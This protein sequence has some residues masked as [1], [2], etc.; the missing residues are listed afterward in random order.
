MLPRGPLAK[1]PS[2]PFFALY[3]FREKAASPR[4]KGRERE[5]LSIL[6]SL[7]P[8]PEGE[9]DFGKK[10][11]SELPERLSMIEWESNL[12]GLCR[13]RGRG[14]PFFDAGEE[15]EAKEG[16]DPELQRNARERAIKLLSSL[17]SPQRNWV[18]MIFDD[19]EV[20]GAH[21]V[22]PPRL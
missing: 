7:P 21:S 13:S 2:P 18:L 20:A 15:G 11:R 16:S 6:F 17:T 8:P 22:F 19:T 4:T 3:T 12:L 14:K 1:I 10:A 5:F 9:T